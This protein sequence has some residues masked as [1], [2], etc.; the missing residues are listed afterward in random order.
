M[1]EARRDG[2]PGL[3]LA[4]KAKL[5]AV[6]IVGA[7]IRQPLGQSGSTPSDPA[8]PSLP[9]GI[10][11]SPDKSSA[12]KIASTPTEINRF[13]TPYQ[14]DSIFILGGVPT[15]HDVLSEY[16]FLPSGRIGPHSDNPVYQDLAAWFDD[17]FRAGDQPPSDHRFQGVNTI[18][19]LRRLPRE[20]GPNGTEAS[21]SATSV[22]REK[23]RAISS[24]RS[25][26]CPCSPAP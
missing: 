9:L 8:L 1:H 10:M 7:A 5:T 15:A 6:P 24:R 19:I 21:Q 2:L 13:A 14:A 25:Q 16:G 12:M 22:L 23:E 26:R 18:A 3:A 4:R 17:K 11:S 20:A